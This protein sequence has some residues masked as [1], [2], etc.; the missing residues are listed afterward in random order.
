MSHIVV[1]VEPGMNVRDALGLAMEH[2]ISHLPV[3]AEGQPLGIVCACE[4]ESAA[5]TSEVSAVMHA[6]PQSVGPEQKFEEAIRVMA[7]R[8]IGSVLVLS[9]DEIVGILTRSDVERV[10]LAREAFGDRHCA[11]CGTY[12]HVRAVPPAGTLLCWN[13]RSSKAAS[14]P[15]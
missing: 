2:G 14:E 10:G 1:G 15:G 7:E 4:L 9:G 8:Q 5:K 12:Q 6:P 11:E 3:V 13:C